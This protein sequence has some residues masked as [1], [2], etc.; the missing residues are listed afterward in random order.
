MHR[1]AVILSGGSQ[2]KKEKFG[3]RRETDTAIM[4]TAR[5]GCLQFHCCSGRLLYRMMHDASCTT[6]TGCCH[7]Y[8][9]CQHELKSDNHDQQVTRDVIL[10]PININNGLFLKLCYRAYSHNSQNNL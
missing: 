2:R 8:Y 1:C 10:I 6:T 5:E 9:Q 7:C 3:C 4:Q